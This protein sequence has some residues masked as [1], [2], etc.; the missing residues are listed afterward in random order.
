MKKRKQLTSL[1]FKIAERQNTASYNL[2]LFN[3]VFFFYRERVI[4][5]HLTLVLASVSIRNNLKLIKTFLTMKP[6]IR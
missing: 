3:F 5:K 4:S 1:Q 6:I 2:L